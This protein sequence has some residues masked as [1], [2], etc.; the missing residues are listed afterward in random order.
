MKTISEMLVQYSWASALVGELIL[1]SIFFLGRWSS[2]RLGK[3]HFRIITNDVIRE[4][5]AMT[6]GGSRY[7]YPSETRG[8]FI[9]ILLGQYYLKHAVWVRVYH[10]MDRPMM[11]FVE[12]SSDRGTQA[13][14]YAVQLVTALRERDVNVSMRVNAEQPQ[15]SF[16]E[17]EDRP[18]SEEATSVGMEEKVVS[19]RS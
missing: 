12:C 10:G 8:Q 13:Y 1:V 9:L 18:W 7:G 14:D 4:Y 16:H 19:L 2:T 17:Q 6:N 5:Y 3:A 11:V 15:L